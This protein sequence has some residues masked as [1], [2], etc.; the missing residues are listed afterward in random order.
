MFTRPAALSDDVVTVV[1]Q[2]AWALRIRRIDNAPVGFGSY[3]WH[4][5]ADEDRWF[6]TA[7]DLLAGQSHLGTSPTERTRRLTAA[8]CTARVLRD[9]GM[10]FVVAPTPTADGEILRIVEERWAV[11]P[12]PIHSR[13]V[14]SVGRLHDER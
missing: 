9:D 6:V 2:D 7:D 3:H 8:L 11:A 10:T 13:L 4:A 12:L 1:V 14:V 5:W